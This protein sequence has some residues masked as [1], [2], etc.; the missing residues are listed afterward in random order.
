MLGTAELTIARPSCP[1]WEGIP[2][3]MAT[4]KQ[5]FTVPAHRL[6]VKLERVVDKDG[7]VKGEIAAYFSA[8]LGSG[9]AY[10]VDLT[11]VAKIDYSTAESFNVSSYDIPSHPP[12]DQEVAEEKDG[13]AEANLVRFEYHPTPTLSIELLGSPSASTCGEKPY[14]L[15]QNTMTTLSVVVLEE[16]GSGIPSCDWVEGEVLVTN[17]LALLLLNKRNI[18]NNALYPS[19]CV[20]ASTC[21]LRT[22]ASALWFAKY[23]ALGD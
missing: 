4:Y 7:G 6:E 13:G 9:R 15:R 22:S 10:P 2:Q 18:C 17:M 11:E 21:W 16:F 3:T 14:I 1:T 8:A 5:V 19:N 12:G 20:N 23:V